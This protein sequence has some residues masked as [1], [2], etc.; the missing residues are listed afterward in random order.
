M[1]AAARW[2]LERGSQSRT[3]RE[4][5]RGRDREKVRETGVKPRF[6]LLADH[7]TG[8]IYIDIRHSRNQMRILWLALGKVA[9]KFGVR[10]FAVRVLVDLAHQ[11]G[12][13]IVLQR[14]THRQTVRL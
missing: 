9:Q 6:N 3:H 7:L 13:V 1:H 4:R 12:V 2:D 11:L 14:H 5:Q 10:D 8:L